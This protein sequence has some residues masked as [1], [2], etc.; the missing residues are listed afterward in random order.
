[1]RGGGG[2]GYVRAPRMPKVVAILLSLALAL[3]L[4]LIG[5]GH[6]E[7]AHIFHPDVSKQL[8]AAHGV[9][10]G[11]PNV[12]GD[13][14]NDY[15]MELYPYGTAMI[16][17]NAAWWMD[18]EPA[19]YEKTEAFW[20]WARGFRHF[21]VLM[22]LLLVAGVT[23]ARGRDLPLAIVLLAGLMLAAEPMHVEL[24]HYGM[25]DVPMVTLL[26][27]A[28]LASAGMG[29]DRTGLHVHALASGFLLG[30]AFGVKYQ[31]LL[32]G[33]FPAVAL[34]LYGWPH[35]WGWML[36][37]GAALGLGGLAGLAISCPMLYTEPHH[38]YV[39]FPQFMAWQANITG[40]DLSTLVKLENNV[41]AFLRGLVVEGRWLLLAP[42]AWAVRRLFRPGNT[43]EERVLGFSALGFCAVLALAMLP[44]RDMVRDN[45]LLPFLP[46]L[47]LAAA[48]MAAKAA[49]PAGRRMAVACCALFAL[50]GAVESTLDSLA[51][52]RTDT[53]IHAAAWCRENLPAGAVVRRENYTPY[54]GAHVTDRAY[55][56]LADPAVTRLLEPGVTDFAIAS[57]LAHERFFDLHF[58]GEGEAERQF[59]RA[60]P[61]RHEKLVE[62]ADRKMMIAHPRITIYRIRGEG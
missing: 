46:F 59:Y 21:S 18:H 33:L 35:G 20:I 12:R 61:L 22:A 8:W 29:R 43:I 24:S 16:V 17:G 28:W 45:D 38:F 23:C 15:R 7:G 11:D 14:Q 52:A 10:N 31:A 26:V 41:P 13:F 4:R 40:N 55:R 47:M 3:V 60:L 39:W 53:R 32:G 54:P 50:H 49:S 2:C 51:L 34:V 56:Y 37:A 5:L 19:N 42:A 27:L 30:L 57:S 36:R 62:F 1:M 58:H 48:W 25:N 44:S 6:G 9:L